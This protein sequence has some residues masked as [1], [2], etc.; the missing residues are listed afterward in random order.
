M[1]DLNKTILNENIQEIERSTEYSNSGVPLDRM[2]YMNPYAGQFKPR[3]EDELKYYPLRP[4]GH[5]DSLNKE[6]EYLNNMISQRNYMEYEP[7]YMARMRQPTP[8]K[9]VQALDGQTTPDKFIEDMNAEWNDIP[10]TK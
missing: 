8:S 4:E 9:Q 10:F 1:P 5:Y 7:E 2:G 3:Y 6:A